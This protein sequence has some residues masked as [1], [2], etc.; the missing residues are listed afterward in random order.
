VTGTDGRKMSTSYGN[1]IPLFEQ[2]KKL[3]KLLGGIVTDST[4]LG[5]PLDPGRCNVFSLLRLFASADE[6]ERIDGWYRSGQR[7]G[8]PFGY[9]HA[10]LLLAEHIERHFAAARERMDSYSR[11]P[12]LVDQVLKRSATRARAIAR[13][14]LDACRRACGLV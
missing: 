4:A 6:L 14:T 5:Q 1:T 3:R 11:E 2:G 13:E 9:G 7:D 8:E 12:E 10:K